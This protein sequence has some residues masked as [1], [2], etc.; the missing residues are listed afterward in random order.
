MDDEAGTVNI[1]R[2]DVRAPLSF[3]RLRNDVNFKPQFSL[4]KGLQS[5]L[6]A[7]REPA[8]NSRLN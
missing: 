1:A 5:Y 8:K 6:K 3:S 2:R 4:A 7:L